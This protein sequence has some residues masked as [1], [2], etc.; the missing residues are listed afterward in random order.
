MKKM[1]AL[2]SAVLTAA[3]LFASCVAI[4]KNPSPA[5][6][7]TAEP[8]AGTAAEKP[9]VP[10]PSELDNRLEAFDFDLMNYVERRLGDE[11]YMISP[12]SFKY[13]LGMLLAGANGQTLDQL[14]TAIGIDSLPELEEY[15]KSFNGFEGC[16]N[17]AVRKYKET[18]DALTDDQ[19]QYYDQPSGALRVANSIWKRTGL[20]D[21]LQGYK[22][23]VSSYYA[24]YRSFTE[25]KVIADVNAWANEKTEGMIPKLLPDD[26]DTS[27]LAVILMNALYYKN[28]WAC[29]FIE[30]PDGDF[31]TVT[32]QKVKKKFISSTEYFRYYSD[33]Q[34]TLVAVPMKNGVDAV[35]VLGSAEDLTKKLSKAEQRRVKVTVP[36]F[37]IETS[38][39]DRQLVD[40]LKERGAKDAFAPDIADF[41]RMFDPEKETVYVDDIV[42]K[43]KIKLDKT[44]VEAAAVT[45]IMAKDEALPET[46]VDFTADKPFRF[47]IMTGRTE[48]AAEGMVMFEGRLTK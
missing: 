32:G 2:I 16:F 9:A 4:P 24:E 19:K 26:Y 17:E 10:G 31:T 20:P 44:G 30:M 48:W 25:D 7:G 46:P 39:S 5:S 45:A 27:N 43:T 34:T 23:A 40:F 42:Q 15:I 13:A 37:E 33:E 12:L 47:F 8:K 41:S 21:F 28:A 35:F 29:E 36:E 6:S 3:A 38:L 14:E 1:I 18:Y 11:S 22:D